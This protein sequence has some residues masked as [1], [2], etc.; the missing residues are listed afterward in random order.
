LHP[1]ASD[2]A[3]AV[4]ADFPCILVMCTHFVYLVPVFLPCLPLS[5]PAP[6]PLRCPCH[7]LPV[8]LFLGLTSL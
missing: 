3:S 2:F 5:R 8:L 1:L 7:R 6:S 4:P